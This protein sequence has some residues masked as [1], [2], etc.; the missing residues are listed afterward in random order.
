MNDS[1]KLAEID[2]LTA[3]IPVFKC[4]EGCTACCGPTMMSRL[5]MARIIKADGRTKKQIEAHAAANV[6][7]GGCACPFLNLQGKCGVYGVRPTIC[8]AFGA[9]DHPRLK[10][11][12]AAP[13]KL[14]SAAEFKA[15]LDKVS[16]LGA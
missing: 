16:E 4:V 2:Q 11:P 10:C 5:E 6:K 9:V 12:H 8:K 1:T 14:M 7:S 13:E 3:T 15:I